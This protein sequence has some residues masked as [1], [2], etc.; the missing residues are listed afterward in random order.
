MANNKYLL[1][2]VE[3]KRPFVNAK[4]PSAEQQKLQKVTLLQL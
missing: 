3:K 1:L 4:L 2:L